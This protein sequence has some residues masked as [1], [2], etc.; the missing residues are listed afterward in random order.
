MT[1]ADSVCLFDEEP[2]ILRKKAQK[3]KL[4]NQENPD[5]ETPTKKR[6]TESNVSLFDSVDEENAQHSM[7]MIRFVPTVED[8]QEIIRIAES[9]HSTNTAQGVREQKTVPRHGKIVCTDGMVGEWSLYKMFQ[10]DTAPLYDTSVR[11]HKT[12]KSKDAT[13]KGKIIEIKTTGSHHNGIRVPLRDAKKPAD[14][15]ALVTAKR[16]NKDVFYTPDEKI[17]CI[18]H[19]FVSAA[20]LLQP[21]NIRTW[22]DGRQYYC[23]TNTAFQPW[24]VVCPES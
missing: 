24:E 15:Y 19:G 2:V 23:L 6:K 21:R 7:S 18:F 11:S 4:E 22:H 20:Q 10:L 16:A 3:R 5:V 8:M 13:I 14:F 9:R 12:D 17:D 1:T